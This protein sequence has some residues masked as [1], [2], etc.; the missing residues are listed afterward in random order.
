MRREKTDGCDPHLLK[1]VAHDLRFQI[2]ELLQERPA[3]PAE[4]AA[5][6]DMPLALAGYHAR[7]LLDQGCLEAVEAADPRSAAERRYRVRPGAFLGGRLRIGVDRVGRAQ[8]AAVMEEALTRLRV[9]HDQSQERLKVV[10]GEATP[11]IVGLAVFEAAR[12]KEA[13]R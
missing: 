13:G 7:V 10:V 1:A 5:E 12:K 3:S 2:L 8:V 9:V 11:L 6:I 4:I